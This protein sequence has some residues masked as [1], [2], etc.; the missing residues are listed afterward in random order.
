MKE[1][2]PA[3]SMVLVQ[4]FNTRQML[5]TK[6]VVDDG[7]VSVASR[8]CPEATPGVDATAMSIDE[9]RQAVPAALPEAPHPRQWWI[10]WLRPRWCLEPPQ[11]A[12]V[13]ARSTFVDDGNGPSNDDLGKCVDL[14]VRVL[15]HFR[16]D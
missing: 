7:G 2:W 5:L 16:F 4:V 6:V 11:A 1:S 12:A 10:R 14:T 8:R 15:T 3:L 9:P 13:A